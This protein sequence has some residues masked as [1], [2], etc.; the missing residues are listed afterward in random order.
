[1]NTLKSITLCAALSIV[2]APAFSETV[3]NDAKSRLYEADYAA[4]LHD[5]GIAVGA[6]VYGQYDADYEA[7]LTDPELFQPMLG[8]YDADYEVYLRHADFADKPSVTLALR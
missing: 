1:M 2:A 8:K 5:N 7:Y 4:V 3:L 6:A